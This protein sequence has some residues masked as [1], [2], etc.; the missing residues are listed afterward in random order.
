MKQLAVFVL[1]SCIACFPQDAPLTLAKQSEHRRVA[2]VRFWS[3]TALTFAATVAD[4]ESTQSAI[5]SGRAREANPLVPAGRAKAYAVE[6]PITGAYCLLSY[7]MKRPGSRLHS[8]LW[9]LPTMA[10]STVHGVGYA[11]NLRFR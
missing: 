7:Y 8:K 2:D 9:W 4:V 10:L 1:F 5:H 11:A 3:M 6:L